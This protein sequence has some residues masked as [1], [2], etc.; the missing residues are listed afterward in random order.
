VA[1]YSLQDAPEL[2]GGT[3]IGEL[4]LAITATEGLTV[5]VGVKGYVGTR[6]GLSGTVNLTYN[7]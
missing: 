3:G 7:F 2:K 6:R 1:G 4:G 5:D